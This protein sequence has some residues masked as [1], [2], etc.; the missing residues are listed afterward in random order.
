MSNPKDN[1]PV[2]IFL[3][4]VFVGFC[5]GAA[6]GSIS[7]RIDGEKA[8]R[9]SAVQQG[10]ATWDDDDKTGEPVFRWRRELVR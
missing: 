5:L 2:W 1:T 7:G 10:F 4:F 8:I 3:M 6:F 9:K